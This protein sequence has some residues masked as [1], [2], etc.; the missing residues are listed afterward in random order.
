LNLLEKRKCVKQEA[1]DT[2]QTEMVSDKLYKVGLIEELE[3]IK[4]ATKMVLG[5][6]IRNFRMLGLIDEQYS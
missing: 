2:F 6:L 3:Q 1:T 4:R 5:Y